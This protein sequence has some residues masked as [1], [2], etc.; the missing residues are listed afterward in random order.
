MPREPAALSRHGQ[1]V[2]CRW[3]YAFLC[4]NLTSQP[5]GRRDRCDT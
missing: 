1:A 4:V 3:T 2:P 5:E